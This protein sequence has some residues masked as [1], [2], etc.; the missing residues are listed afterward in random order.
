MGWGRRGEMVMG[1]E[2]VGRTRIMGV[3]RRGRER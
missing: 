1:V 2:A 3:G